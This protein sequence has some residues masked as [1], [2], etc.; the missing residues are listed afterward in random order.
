MPHSYVSNLVHYVFSTKE[1]FPSIDRELEIRLWPYVGGI[2]RE[3]E[4]AHLR[5]VSI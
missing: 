2:A 5:N 3:N 1:R 4:S